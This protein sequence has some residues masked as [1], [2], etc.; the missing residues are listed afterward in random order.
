MQDRYVGDVGDYV[1]LAILR[2]LSP[3]RRLGV[4]WWLFP[5]SG[6]PGDG[7]HTSY[8]KEPSKWQHFAP[9]V[10]DALEKIVG[11]D[12]RTVAALE[13]ADLLPGATYF[14]ELIP[15]GATPHETRTRREEWFARCQ[16]HLTD[17]NLVFLDP[18]NGFEPK[19]FSLGAR[20]GGKSVSMAALQALRLSGRTLVVYHHHTRLAGGHIAELKRWGD[21]L[22]A[23]GFDRVDAL[24]ATPYS[25]RAFFLLNAD[26]EIRDR[27]AA[28]GKQ[29]AGLIT[30]YRDCVANAALERQTDG[31]IFSVGEDVIYDGEAAVMGVAPKTKVSP[32]ADLSLRE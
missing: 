20:N 10:Y 15:I 29:W 26:D 13:D 6:T 12:R 4:A 31:G 19:G 17:C 28:L 8:L 7:R 2:A 18:D 32:P 16:A 30:W 27:A 23:L 21:H 14:S 5:D 9:E 25:P 11:S 24:R 3:G 1:K 22:L